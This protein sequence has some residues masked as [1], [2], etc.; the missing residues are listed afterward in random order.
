MLRRP[1]FVRVVTAAVLAGCASCQRGEDRGGAVTQTR[2]GLEIGSGGVTDSQ[3]RLWRAATIGPV[4][5]ASASYEQAGNGSL[6]FTLTGSGPGAAFAHPGLDPR[7]VDG[8]QFVGTQVAGD[9]EIVVRLRDA[10]AD[11]LDEMQAGVMIRDANPTIDANPARMGA[12]WLNPG[13]P[14]DIGCMQTPER[15]ISYF[16]SAARVTMTASPSDVDLVLRGGASHMT[17]RIKATPGDRPVWLRL[18]RVGKDFSFARSRDGNTWAPGGGGEFAPTTAVIGVFVGAHWNTNVIHR[19]PRATFDSVYVGPPRRAYTTSWLGAGFAQDSTGY[20]S[21]E[22]E[23]LYVAPEGTVIKYAATPREDHRNFDKID[24]ATGRPINIAPEGVGGFVGVVE[25]G[26]AGDGQHL[27]VGIDANFTQTDFHVQRRT[28]PAL[29]YDQVRSASLGQIVGLAAAGG[30]VYVSDATN[31]L[32]RV[33]SASTLV[34]DSAKTFAFSRPGPLAVDH[35]GRIWVVRR[36]AKYP[37]Y[38]QFKFS[39]ASF[40]V[41]P[42]LTIDDTILRGDI[43]ENCPNVDPQNPQLADCPNPLFGDGAAIACFNP[44]KS[45]CRDAS[46]NPIVIRDVVANNPTALAAAPGQ[47]RLLIADNGPDQNVRVCTTSVNAQPDCSRTFGERGGAFAGPTPGLIEDPAGSGAPRFFSLVGLGVDSGGNLYVASSAPKVEVRK[48]AP[49]ADGLWNRQPSWRYYGLHGFEDTGGFDPETEGRDFFSPWQHFSLDPTRTEPGKEWSQKGV[50]WTPFASYPDAGRF[51]GL[52]PQVQVRHIGGPNGP[53]F[54]FVHGPENSRLRIY[55]FVGEMAVP[56][57]SISAR[58]SEIAVWIDGSDGSTPD[59]TPQPSEVTSQIPPAPAGGGFTYDVDRRGHI[60][61]IFQTLAVWELA[62]QMMATGVPRYTLATR[63][64]STLPGGPGAPVFRIHASLRFDSDHDALYVLGATDLPDGVTR[65]AFCES[66]QMGGLQSTLVRYSNWHGAR[67]RAYVVNLPDPQVTQTQADDTPMRNADP[68]CGCTDWGYISFDI[69]GDMLFFAERQSYVHVR[70]ARTGVEVARLSHGPEI[71]GW[72]GNWADTPNYLGVIRRPNGEYLIAN[73]DDANSPRTILYRWTPPSSPM[74]PASCTSDQPCT[75]DVPGC[76]A[77]PGLASCTAGTLGPCIAGLPECTTN[78]PGSSCGSMPGH[79]SCIPGPVAGQWQLAGE[80][81]TGRREPAGYGDEVRDTCDG[82]DNDC[83][84]TIDEDNL[85]PRF[86]LTNQVVTRAG[87]NGTVSLTVDVDTARDAGECASNEGGQPKLRWYQSIA[88]GWSPVAQ[89]SASYTQQI[90]APPATVTHAIT[91]TDTCAAHPVTAALHITS[92][93][94]APGGKALGV[95]CRNASE[96]Q[97]GYCVCKELD[98]YFG[99]VCCESACI[100]T[101]SCQPTTC[102]PGTG[103]C[104]RPTFPDG[105]ACTDGS[106]CT[107]EDRCQ[108]GVCRG[109]PVVPPLGALGDACTAATGCA[110][111]FCVDG[112]CCQSACTSTSCTSFHCVNVDDQ[113]GTCLGTMMP[114]GTACNDGDACTTVD[115]CQ[116]GACVGTRSGRGTASFCSATCRCGSGDGDCDSAAECQ[117]G[118]NCVAHVGA[119]FGMSASTDVCVNWDPTCST[120][121]SSGSNVCCAASCGACGGSGC[122]SRPGG[123]DAC[124]LTNIRN[125]GVSC[126]ESGPPCVLS[127]PECKTGIRSGNVCCAYG[128]GTCGGTGCSGRPGGSAAC[129]SGTIQAAGRSCATNMPPCVMP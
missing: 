36:A 69:A 97:S 38:R 16:Q 122:A 31:G 57:G 74:A 77:I 43:Y 37:S 87:G 91:A 121:I 28:L 70:D 46:G 73:Y 51:P 8:V 10:D 34:E 93:F 72:P 13:N 29:S 56:C 50:T 85:P 95:D 41:R 6:S 1:S 52:S 7:R 118:L 61:F 66:L 79:R 83:D 110:S 42:R 124:C 102:T 54:L 82:I 15:E 40:A 63:Q 107:T 64:E 113:R 119:S 22:G 24:G 125:D 49:S 23:G 115:T 108:G 9:V 59:G 128:C 58:G 88:G 75:A 111:G 101:D 18:Q 45:A 48:F 90:P 127:D 81:A 3:G 99:R 32:V 17:T 129:C 100:S 67:A 105:M 2:A 92:A 96:C 27:Y 68:L 47:D 55:R 4:T 35:R 20:P 109:T 5:G 104:N 12:G 60:W 33:L 123:G 98:C 78:V 26:V 62:P 30:S 39:R 112:I 19:V 65:S 116:S 120:G 21:L 53:R 80:C 94:P 89:D 117:P 14:T 76:G 106:A 86:K 114:E 44:D 84:G 25:G 126:T 11:P 103:A 71:S